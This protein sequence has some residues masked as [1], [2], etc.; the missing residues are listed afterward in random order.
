MSV[1]MFNACKFVPVTPTQKLVL[2]TLADCHN[3][4]DNRCDPSVAYMM[5]ITG[6]S[7]RA[8]ADAIAAL[9]EANVI[10][11]NRRHGARSSYT[12]T[13]S[14]QSTSEPASPVTG[15]PPSPVT[16]APPVNVAHSTSEPGSLEPV[17]VAPEP[18]S[19]VH[20]NRKN[21]NTTGKE[22]E[23][24]L[25]ANAP[26]EPSPP[27]PAKQPKTDWR[28]AARAEADE[29]SNTAL[30]L[31]WS[32]PLR[33]AL[34]EFF[35]HRHDLA[36]KAT[37]KSDHR[38]W[39][40]RSATATVAGVEAAL[41]QHGEAAVLAHIHK[42]IAGGW[43]GLNLDGIRPANGHKSPQGPQRRELDLGFRGESG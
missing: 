1:R 43:Q 15:E 40:V 26:S 29:A 7:N 42:A 17:N 32:Q 12:L 13:P 31:L 24:L 35:A 5:Q 11:V 19:Q 23:D 10:A 2:M 16:C 22:P 34:L 36:T 41:A 27:P 8:I 39:T 21:Q 25:S 28:A 20:T 9:E 4:E 30:P 14:N 6:L 33:T 18:V 37:T 3:G 38:R